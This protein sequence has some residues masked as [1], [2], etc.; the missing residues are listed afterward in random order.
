M[1]RNVRVYS[2]HST[3]SPS[4]FPLS[5]SPPLS[6]TLLLFFAL[7]IDF[8][9]ILHNFCCWN[10]LFHLISDVFHP[11]FLMELSI[12]MPSF[13]R[14]ALWVAL[15]LARFTHTQNTLIT[16]FIFVF[17]D[18]ESDSILL[19]WFKHTNTLKCI[20]SKFPNWTL[21][22]SSKSILF[23]PFPNLVSHL[24][25]RSLW[26]SRFIFVFV[27]CVLIA[28]DMWV[29][30]PSGE[31]QN[32]LSLCCVFQCEWD[33]VGVL[34]VSN[35]PPHWGAHPHAGGQGVCCHLTQSHC[36]RECVRDWVRAR[37]MRGKKAQTSIIGEMCARNDRQV[38]E[39]IYFKLDFTAFSMAE[40]C[41]KRMWFDPLLLLS[42]LAVDL[43]AYFFLL[44]SHSLS[45][46]LLSYHLL[47][48]Y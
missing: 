43:S 2:S 35:G 11:E 39:M 22:T 46:S 17:F 38:S 5:S 21:Q 8:L 45:H 34:F 42:L 32:G 19:A 48:D 30:Q 15:R 1:R 9:M 23:S 20:M 4:L 7:E 41:E 44:L 37:Q 29:L 13:M 28:T 16:L 31:V 6:L 18:R 14:Y 40:N 12:R 33:D 47:I 3:I 36:Q 24:I 26:T 25:V 27:L 10:S